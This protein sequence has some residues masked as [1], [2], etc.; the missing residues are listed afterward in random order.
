MATSVVGRDAEAVD[1]SDG[2]STAATHTVDTAADNS[3]AVCSTSS[4]DLQTGT[5]ADNTVPSTMSSV[6]LLT[7]HTEHVSTDSDISPGEV[8]NMQSVIV[9]PQISPAGDGF[10]KLTLSYSPLTME[11]V[12]SDRLSVNSRTAELTDRHVINTTTDSDDVRH[13]SV[14]SSLNGNSLTQ[15]F[16]DCIALLHCIVFLLS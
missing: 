2:S 7:G 4:I 16:V 1:A 3:H 6:S 10:V 5:T 14:D 13:S 9:G 8:T 12:V 15:R 11:T